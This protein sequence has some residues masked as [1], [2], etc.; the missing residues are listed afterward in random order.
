MDLIKLLKIFSF[1]LSK[2]NL[3]TYQKMGNSTII[4]VIAVS[5]LIILFLRHRKP[6]NPPPSINQCTP[7]IKK[8]VLRIVNVMSKMLGW[9]VGFLTK[10]GLNKNG[11][12]SKDPLTINILNIKNNASDMSKLITDGNSKSVYKYMVTLFQNFKQLDGNINTPGT[13]LLHSG[14]YNTDLIMYNNFFS[15]TGAVLHDLINWPFGTYCGT[16]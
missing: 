6:P 1:G 14:K 4:L 8:M 11:M 15:Q 2:E 5:A 3:N 10:T 16:N 13:I 12:A 9:W 7:I